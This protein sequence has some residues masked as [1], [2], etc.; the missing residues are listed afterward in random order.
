[1][2]SMIAIAALALSAA[3]FSA[4]LAAQDSEIAATA[5]P[6]PAAGKGQVVFFRP[7]GMGMAVKCTVRENGQFVTRVGNS[8]Y[9][10]VEVDPGTH[11]FTAKSES[12]DTIN[13]LVEEGETSYAKCKISMG[14]M[15]GRP[16]LSPSNEEEFRAVSAKVKRM[17]Q[18]KLA[19]E[20]AK[21]AADLA[22][23]GAS[24]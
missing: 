7:S 18:D 16:N 14:V 20:K 11:T 1:M 4:P 6:T 21:D 19:E 23:K 12:T 24:Q 2:K 8:R 5:L 17:D 13:L 3:T 22:K 10:V 15:V 9:D